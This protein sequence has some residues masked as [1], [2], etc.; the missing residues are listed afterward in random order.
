M[1]IFQARKKCPEGIFLGI[2]MDRYREV[3]NRIMEILRLFSPLVEQVSIDEAYLDLT[4]TWKLLGNSRDIALM[5]KQKIR[6]E[7]GL[8]CSVG[9]APN[10]FLAKISS[11]MQKPDG[12]TIISPAQVPGVIDNLPIEKVPGVGEKSIKAL[13]GIGLFKL[14]DVKRFGDRLLMKKTGSFAKRII[15]LSRGIDDTPVSPTTD[16]KSISSEDTLSADTNDVSLLKRRLLY[17]SEIVGRRLRAKGYKG[18]TVTLKIKGA[19]FKQKTRSV[20]LDEPTCSSQTIYEKGLELLKHLDMSVK[21]RL[22]GIGVSNLRLSEGSFKQLNLFSESAGH[23]K[24]SWSEAEKA[25]D[26]IKERFGRDAIKRGGL[27]KN[28]GPQAE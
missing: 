25:M 20:T 14:G 21:Y 22:I 10:R 15:G 19:D 2:R 9:I 28:T 12:L 23:K 27:L 1:P 26:V 18:T 13:H 16:H 6:D 17:Q 7:T 4:G 8:T 11:D 3:S 5:M 24:E